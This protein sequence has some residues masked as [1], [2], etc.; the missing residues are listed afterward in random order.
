MDNFSCQQLYNYIYILN[1]FENY[2][3]FVIIRHILLEK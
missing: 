1:V 3:D 2:T